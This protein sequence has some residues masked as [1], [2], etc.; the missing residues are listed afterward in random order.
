MRG[1]DIPASRRAGPLSWAC[2]F[3]SPVISRHS[4]WQGPGFRWHEAIYSGGMGVSSFP[5]ERSG[6]VWEEASA[7]ASL[8]SQL[9]FNEVL[10][11]QKQKCTEAEPLA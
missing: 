3:R 4:S 10:V 11:F 8:T 6:E 2:G 1:T 7:S 5:P 9:S